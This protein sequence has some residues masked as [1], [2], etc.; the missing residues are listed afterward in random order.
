MRLENDKL[1]KLKKVSQDAKQ[2]KKKNDRQR[3]R[4]LNT[5]IAQAKVD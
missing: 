4:S 1:P 2:D 5:K 3:I